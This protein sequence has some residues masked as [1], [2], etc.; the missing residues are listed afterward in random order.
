LSA[1]SAAAWSGRNVDAILAWFAAAAVYHNMPIA[2]M[3]GH[4]EIRSVL[5]MFVPPASKIEF[6]ILALASRADNP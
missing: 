5:E 1:S 3:R 6:E 2:H 4:P